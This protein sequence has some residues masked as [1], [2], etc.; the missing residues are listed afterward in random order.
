MTYAVCLG[1]GVNIIQSSI[2]WTAFCN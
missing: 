2:K 1:E